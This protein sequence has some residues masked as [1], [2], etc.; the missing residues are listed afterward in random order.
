MGMQIPTVFDVIALV[1][2]ISTPIKVSW[3]LWFAWGIAQAGWYQRAHVTAPATAATPRPLPQRPRGVARKR[4]DPVAAPA[5]AEPADVTAT[6]S[7]PPPPSHG[8]ET[9]DLATSS[10]QP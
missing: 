8:A 5:P 6:G 2:D 7:E 4:P 10:A 3:I 9:A 1:N